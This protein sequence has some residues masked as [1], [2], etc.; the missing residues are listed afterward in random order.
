MKEK[1]TNVIQTTVSNKIQQIYKKVYFIAPK[2][3]I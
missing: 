2:Q 1:Q 3:S